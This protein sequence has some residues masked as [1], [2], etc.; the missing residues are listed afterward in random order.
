MNP[1]PA[2]KLIA[3]LESCFH[4][5]RLRSFKEAPSDSL[6]TSFS[7]SSSSLSRIK[8]GLLSPDSSSIDASANDHDT[9][10]D[11]EIDDETDDAS[12][13][14]NPYPLTIFLYSDFLQLYP[15]LVKKWA[16]VFHI[17]SR[18]QR[19]HPP[20]PRYPASSYR[21]SL[22]AATRLF[23]RHGFEPDLLLSDTWGVS[24]I[25]LNQARNRGLSVVRPTV[26]SPPFYGDSYSYLEELYY[27]VRSVER[28]PK[29]LRFINDGLKADGGILTLDGDHEDSHLVSVHLMEFLRHS[30]YYDLV[31]LNQCF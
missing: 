16:Q 25:L 15:K 27:N 10:G 5:L 9:D 19:P 30:N 17:A 20:Y 3:T 11:V 4:L 8:Y 14:A 31:P 1:L 24:T 18:G 23:R 22:I 13:R 21:K 12:R 7:A 26:A 28:T 6:S 2:M 29:A